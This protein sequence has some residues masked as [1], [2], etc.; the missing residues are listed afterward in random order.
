LA[1]QQGNWQFPPYWQNFIFWFFGKELQV[2]I[3][4]P[5]SGFSWI[6]LSPPAL[7]LGAAARSDWGQPDWFD[8]DAWARSSVGFVQRAF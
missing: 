7:K 1:D 8:A 2:D 6:D 3:D 5:A 4:D